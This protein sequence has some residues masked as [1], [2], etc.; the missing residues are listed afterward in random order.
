MASF[1]LWV[2][3]LLHFCDKAL[4]NRNLIKDIGDLGLHSAILMKEALI[5][6]YVCV[7]WARISFHTLWTET[8]D[9]T[10]VAFFKKEMLKDLRR[11]DA[12]CVPTSYSWI[13]HLP[14][15]LNDE[16]TKLLLSLD[17]SSHSLML[18][19][20]QKSRTAVYFTGFDNNQI[21]RA[22]GTHV[23]R[24]L[25]IKLFHPYQCLLLHKFTSISLFS[26]DTRSQQSCFQ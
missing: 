1:L 21:F 22:I 9:K 5:H 8:S 19:I 7:S 23:L 4:T 3:V 13:K 11:H 12:D 26:D 20:Q 16:V 10:P 15:Y 24:L 25:C 14:W 17:C 6:N 2:I 18:V